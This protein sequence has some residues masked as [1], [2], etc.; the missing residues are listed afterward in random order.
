MQSFISEPIHNIYD[1]YL[2]LTSLWYDFNMIQLH[3]R[4]YNFIIAH[5]NFYQTLGRKNVYWMN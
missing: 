3:D 2:D 4:W 5:K 1:T